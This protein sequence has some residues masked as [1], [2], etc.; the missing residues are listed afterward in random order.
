MAKLD[1]LGISSNDHN[2]KT[3]QEM[4]YKFYNFCKLMVQLNY[5]W[6]KGALKVD[7]G[8]YKH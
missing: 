4:F 7:F 1:P 8:G 6:C 5:Y 3:S 2:E